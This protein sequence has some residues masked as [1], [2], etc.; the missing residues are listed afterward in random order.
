MGMYADVSI[1][2][3]EY[4]CNDVLTV[5]TPSMLLSTFVTVRSQPEHVIAGRANVCFMVKHTKKENKK[6]HGLLRHY[7]NAPTFAHNH[8]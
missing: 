7:E 3:R 5:V 8:L 6:R 1:S 2:T 4:G